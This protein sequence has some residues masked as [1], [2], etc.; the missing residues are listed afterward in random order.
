MLL[1]KLD[2]DL[3]KAY[4]E[5]L[6]RSSGNKEAIVWKSISNTKTKESIFINSLGQ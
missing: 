4:I 3:F 5:K 2:S 1:F 6:I